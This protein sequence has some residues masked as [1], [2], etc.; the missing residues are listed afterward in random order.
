[1]YVH[2]V[3]LRDATDKQALSFSQRL[4]ETKENSDAR[5]ADLEK[6]L[7]ERLASVESASSKACREL[8]DKVTAALSAANESQTAELERVTSSLESASNQLREDLTAL[9]VTMEMG[10]R[11]LKAQIQ[12]AAMKVSVLGEARQNLTLKKLERLKEELSSTALSLGESIYDTSS[13]TDQ[14]ID[15]QIAALEQTLEAIGTD[16]NQRKE[17][18]EA[19]RALEEKKAAIKAA[20]ERAKQ[21]EAKR[22]SP[23]G[24]WDSLLNGLRDEADECEELGDSEGADAKRLEIDQVKEQIEQDSNAENKAEDPLPR[25]LLERVEYR[26]WK[27]PFKPGLLDDY[28][29]C[30]DA[31][32]AANIDAIGDDALGKDKLTHSLCYHFTTLASLDLIMGGH[33]LRAS[34]AGQLN[35]GLS[36]CVSNMSEMKWEQWAGNRF[37]EQVGKELW[38]TKWKDLLRSGKT[39]DGVP[40]SSDGKDC[41]K[42]DYVIVLKVKN[43]VLADKKRIVSGRD[44]VYIIHKDFLTE[45]D[46]FHY[47]GR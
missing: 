42:I 27:A 1:M 22:R 36:V 43:E 31:E 14:K 7:L 40:V 29:R 39:S 2:A 17:A 6:Q 4:S 13:T 19:A 26:A 12:M 34:V 28:A 11:S 44:N 16:Y 33:G 9:G 5:L 3:A 32:M 47:L 25:D 41:D 30:T 15:R 20:E 37:R 45:V 8:D 24:V 46:G 18:E 23:R 10:D 35:G 38:G 21:E